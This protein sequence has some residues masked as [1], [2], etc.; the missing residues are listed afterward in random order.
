MI[1]AIAKY[2]LKI[3]N[4]QEITEKILQSGHWLYSK[5]IVATDMEN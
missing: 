4:L 3:G 5:D 2:N 1:Y